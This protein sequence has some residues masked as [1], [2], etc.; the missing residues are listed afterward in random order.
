MWAFLSA[1]SD[2][3]GVSA[4]AG[5]LRQV[6]AKI[7]GANTSM[8]RCPA[9]LPR[10]PARPRSPHHSPSIYMLRWAEPLHRSFR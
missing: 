1:W 3:Y 5:F 2:L 6:S 4:D 7:Q 9:H 10:S 8:R